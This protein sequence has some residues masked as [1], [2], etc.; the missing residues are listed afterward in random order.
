LL[1]KSESDI[2]DLGKKHIVSRI[3][4][5]EN[6]REFLYDLHLS[7]RGYIAHLT[8]PTERAAA[9]F[10]LE[11]ARTQKLMSEKL[12]LEI[13]IKSG[14]VVQRETLLKELVEQ[15]SRFKRRLSAIPARVAGSFAETEK[16]RRELERILEAEVSDSLSVLAS[17]FDGPGSNGDGKRASTDNGVT[18]RSG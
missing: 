1:G 7:V 8:A 6:R 14:K 2:S 10:T 17:I 18:S 13:A 12:S 16:E 11:K 9:R 3:P 4:N 15:F 5:P